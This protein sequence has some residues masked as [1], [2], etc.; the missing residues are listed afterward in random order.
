MHE[1][2]DPRLARR[3][4]QRKKNL[5]KQVDHLDG[6]LNR[7]ARV[8]GDFQNS[9]RDAETLQFISAVDNATKNLHANKLNKVTITQNFK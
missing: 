6:V 9:T 7:I 5:E 8:E 2:T 1:T 3:A 4:L